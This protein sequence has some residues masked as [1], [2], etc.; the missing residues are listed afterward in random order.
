MASV[1]ATLPGYYCWRI[2]RSSSNL[3][4][5]LLTPAALLVGFLLLWPA[6][7]VPWVLQAWMERSTMAINSSGTCST[8][9]V[10]FTL[11]INIIYIMP[12][13]VTIYSIFLAVIVIVI[14]LV[15]ALLF[16][17][18]CDDGIRSDVGVIGIRYA[19]ST[20]DSAYRKIDST[21]LSSASA[22]VAKTKHIGFGDAGAGVSLNT[23]S[24]QTEEYLF[25][26]YQSVGVSNTHIHE[27]AGVRKT[28]VQESSAGVNIERAMC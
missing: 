21:Y 1:L 19:T 8:N 2:S 28:G 16:R 6:I 10:L 5:L 7:G 14:V 23:G 3:L 18:C 27:E 24:L 13:L 26:A 4:V 25:T 20:T 15:G 17:W 22:D 11:V 9:F 12:F